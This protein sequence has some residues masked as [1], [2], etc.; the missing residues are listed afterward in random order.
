MNLRMTSET[1]PSWPPA[2]DI[3]LRFTRETKDF[4]RR[5][6]S[7]SIFFS[8]QQQ[9]RH[10]SI[11]LS[12]NILHDPKTDVTNSQRS[13]TFF[14]I[15]SLRNDHIQIKM[16]DFSR[17]LIFEFEISKDPDSDQ[18]LSRI[19][20]S[21]QRNQGHST[22]TYIDALKVRMPLLFKGKP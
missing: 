12:E 11:R 8:Q 2:D 4:S 9:L 13:S 21:P 17:F 16:E 14:A 18:I 5:R 6:R 15:Y 19:Q 1:N 22:Q 3:N 20:R 7:R 10:K